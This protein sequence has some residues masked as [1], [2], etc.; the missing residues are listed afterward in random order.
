MGLKMKFKSI[1]FYL[2]FASGL[3]TSTSGITQVQI[4]AGCDFLRN[5]EVDSYSSTYGTLEFNA[6]ERIVISS[7]LPA[8]SGTPITTI[9]SLD[10]V[11][12]DT[13]GFPGTV[14]YKFLVDRTVQ[15]LWA[16]EGSNPYN[17]GNV[18]WTTDCIADDVVYVPYNSTGIPTLKWQ[19]V[20]VLITLLTGFA[21]Y[22]RGKFTA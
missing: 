14:S 6:G 22:H 9:L 18:T 11:V 17:G 15:I 1:V 12:V 5:Q 19:G 3:A 7:G 4:E 13:D 2:V 16:I 10:S 21:Y 20:A 8:N